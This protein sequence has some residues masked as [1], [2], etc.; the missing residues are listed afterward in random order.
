[1]QDKLN[2]KKAKQE[3]IDNMVA[4]LK[5]GVSEHFKDYNL[6]VDR[7]LFA[8]MMDMYFNSVPKEQQPDFLQEIFDKY[9]G[10]WNKY[11]EYVF[12]KSIFNDPDKV[13]VFLSKPNAKILKKDPALVAWNNFY[14]K[15]KDLN[16]EIKPYSNLKARGHRLFIAGLMEMN[17]DKNFY[18]NA[19]FTMRVTYG[20]IKSYDPADAVHYDYV[21]HLYGVMQKE[22]PDNQEFIVPEKLKEIYDKKDYGQYGEDGKLITDFISTNDITGGNSGSPIMNGNGE[23]I[24]LAFDGNWEAMSGDI[25]FDAE[26]QRTINVDVRYVLMIIDKYAG[27]QNLIDELTIIKDRPEE[28]KLDEMKSDDIKA[29]ETMPDHMKPVNVD[30][31][32]V[33]QPEEMN[34]EKVI[35]E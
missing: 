25:K 13:E 30:E 21:T 33:S 26:L 2:D 4:S 17:P 35:S 31:E 15:Y 9:H 22:D 23:L 5:D 12:E 8:A 16:K 19:N 24:G 27:A 6:E 29:D 28:I 14:D 32:K 10:D 7:N 18:P 11:A 20:T 3:D 1:L 34:K